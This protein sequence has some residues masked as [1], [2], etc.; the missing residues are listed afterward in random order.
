TVQGVVTLDGRPLEIREGMRGTV[1]YQPAGANGITLNGA[2]DAT[3]R[4][5]LSAGSS[6]A[7][8]PS[9]YWATVSVVEVLPANEERPQ[10][11]GRRITPAKYATATDSG[12]RIEVLPGAN[13][14]DLELKSEKEPGDSPV[15][16]GQATAS[17]EDSTTH[18]E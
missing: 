11:T 8:V 6:T 15:T 16:D 17:A 5:E 10:A 1:V 12:F 9:V 4:Y 3:G 2:I 7:V 14:V 13:E 18:S